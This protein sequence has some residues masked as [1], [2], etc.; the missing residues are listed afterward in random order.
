MSK[1][2]HPDFSELSVT[3]VSAVSSCDNATCYE[4]P[5]L[6]TRSCFRIIGQAKATPLGRILEAAHEWVEPG[7]KV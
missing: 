7:V 2:T 6:C 4:L 5:V 3:F 1:T